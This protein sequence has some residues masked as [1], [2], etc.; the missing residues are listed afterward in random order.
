MQVKSFPLNTSRSFIISALFA[1]SLSHCA[2]NKDNEFTD[3]GENP[4]PYQ[5]RIINKSDAFVDAVRLKPCGAPAKYY[6]T[7]TSGVKPAEKVTLNVYS[8]CIDLVAEDGFRQTV[9]E[10]K[11]IKMTQ[12]TTLH[13]E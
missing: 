12:N 5:M 8:V 10:Q 9:Y 4:D 13:I 1:L 7:V 6:T 11:N 3:P 2:S